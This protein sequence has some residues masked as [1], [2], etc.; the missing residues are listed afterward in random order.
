MIPFS[1]AGSILRRRRG[2]IRAVARRLGPTGW[3]A[4]LGSSA[5]GRDC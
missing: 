1:A 5:C 2:D 3:G 4:D